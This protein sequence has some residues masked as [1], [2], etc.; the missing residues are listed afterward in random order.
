MLSAAYLTGQTDNPNP[1]SYCIKMDLEPE[2][3]HLIKIYK[4]SDKEM[5]DRL[6]SYFQR[7]NKET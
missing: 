3:F 6:L 5:K 4:N 1:D 2:L 7:I